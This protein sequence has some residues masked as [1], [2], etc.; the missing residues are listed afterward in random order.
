M[1]KR[2]LGIGTETIIGKNT[3]FGPVH[4]DYGTYHIDKDTY[5]INREY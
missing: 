2:N 5:I 3:V 1:A 4:S